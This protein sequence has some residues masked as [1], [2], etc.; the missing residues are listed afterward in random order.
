M[1][2]TGY[3]SQ[4]ADGELTFGQFVWRCARAFGALIE[5]RDSSLDAVPPERFESSGYEQK[6]LDESKARLAKLLEMTPVEVEKAQLARAKENRKHQEDIRESHRQKRT[7][8]EAMLAQAEAWET[9]SDEHSGLKDFMVS[10]LRE[11]IEFDCYEIKDDYLGKV[12][13]TGKEWLDAEIASAQ[14]RVSR[15]EEDLRKSLERTDSRNLWLK[16]LRDSVP[17]ERQP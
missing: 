13:G 2:P 11:S 3:T 7:N 6:S 1:M 8:Y 14:L 15:D 4:V 12:P 17:F 9:P 5:M 10:Q 16:D